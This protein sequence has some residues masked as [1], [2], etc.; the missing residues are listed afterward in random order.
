MSFVSF[1]A[2]IKELE[3]SLEVTSLKERVFLS[4]SFGRVVA[5]DIVASF[6]SPAFATSA[7]DGYAIKFEDQQMGRIR[8][9]GDNPAGS[10]VKEEVIGGTCIKTFTGS[11]MPNGSDTLIPIE[12]VEVDGEFIV[13]KE[14]V[15]K[16]ANV[17]AIGENFQKNEVLIKKGTK[18][19]FAEIGV[20]ASLNISQVE[21]F[22]KPTVGVLSTGSEILDVGEIQTSEAQIRSSN[23]FVLESLSK[24]EGANVIR[25]SLIGDDKESIKNALE[26]L[27]EKCDIVVTTGGV[28][29][30]DYD[31][32]K[33]ILADMEPEYITKGVFIK[34]GQHIKIVK[35]GKK[36]IVAL[37]GFPYSSTV[38]FIT[39]VV[40]IIRAMMG[41]NPKLKYKKA[42]IT[43]DFKKKTNNKTE[44]HVGNLELR[45]GR[46]FVNFECKKSGTSA[47]L[48][49]MLGSVALV[50]IE[51]EDD[52]LKKGQEVD[53]LDMEDF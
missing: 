4:D 13:I 50:K 23:Q 27:L 14:E 32:V 41:L 5:N 10:D 28:S 53:I 18:L 12:F 36:Y 30:G 38:T 42:I 15:K 48:T 19:G 46:Y 26:S 1:D 52:D 20:M 40:P 44:F 51:V 6:N 37:P 33:S 21:V 22:A 43:H 24:K 3:K 29:V 39:Y 11:L 35:L 34:P 49:N 7:M 25:H 47:I 2:S 17:R 45:D 16:G 31:F 8:I 9:V